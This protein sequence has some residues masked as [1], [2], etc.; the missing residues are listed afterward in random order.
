MTAN[1]PLEITTTRIFNAPPETVWRAWTDPAH[2]SNWW[3]PT[4]F[5][6][7]IHKM[8]FVQNGEWNFVMHGPDGT[9]YQNRKIF[10][11]ISFPT[12]IVMQHDGHPRHTMTVTFEPYEAGTLLT[13]HHLFADPAEYDIAIQKHGAVEGARQT[14][15]RFA[16]SLAK[17]QP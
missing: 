15:N 7:T 9:D 11:E 4:G 8:D 16:E 14:L 3:G 12:R 6:V 2:I 5:S 17:A 1:P 13:L 10:K